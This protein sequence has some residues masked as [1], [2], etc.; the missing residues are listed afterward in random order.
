M[1]PRKY[2]VSMICLTLIALLLAGCGSKPAAPTA[3]PT[4]AATAPAAVGYITG[5]VYLAGP[6]T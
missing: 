5:K 6:P 2:F 4:V 3:A 1:N